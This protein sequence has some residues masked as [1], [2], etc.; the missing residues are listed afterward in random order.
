MSGVG[1]AG[2]DHRRLGI[3]EEAAHIVKQRRLIAFRAKA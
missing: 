1:V 2:T 3:V